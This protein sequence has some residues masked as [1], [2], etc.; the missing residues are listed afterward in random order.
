MIIRDSTEDVNLNEDLETYVYQ[1]PEAMKN[2]EANTEIDGTWRQGGPHDSLEGTGALLLHHM[3]RIESKEA[4][5][6]LKRDLIDHLWKH[7]HS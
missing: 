2:D 1:N 4:H 5:F 7:R 3:N 6:T